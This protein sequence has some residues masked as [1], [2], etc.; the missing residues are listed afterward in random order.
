MKEQKQNNLWRLVATLALALSI[1]ASSMISIGAQTGI[2][3]TGGGAKLVAPSGTEIEIQSG[4]TLDIQSGATT[5]FS[6]GVDLDGAALTVDADGDSAM[7]ASIDDQITTTLGAATGA[8]GIATGN[9]R[10]GNG[11]NDT[12]LNG[13]DMYVEGTLEVDGAVN[14]DG[15]VDIDGNL[16]SATGAITIADTLNA[17]GAVDF[18]STLN[19]DGAVTIPVNIEHF[20]AM[21]VIT[22][23]ITYTAAAGGNG[24]VATITDGEIWLVHAVFWQTTTNFDCTGDDCTATVG[25]GNVAAGFLSLNDAAMQAAFTEATGFAAGFYG[26]ENGSAGAYTT[27]DGGPFVYAPSGADETID[28]VLAAAGDDFSAGAATI[29]VM[30]TRIQ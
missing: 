13:E 14:L 5:D 18:D 19:V 20:G 11:A 25:D 15:A 23:P 3:R 6:G 9:L 10:V 26:I 17:T 2:Y 29:Y 27:D 24:V 22:T 30:Y 4:A 16:T 8:F 7:Q 21:S 12:A 28:W 1:F